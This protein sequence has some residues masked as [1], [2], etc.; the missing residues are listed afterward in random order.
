MEALA[1]EW[2]LDIC[3]SKLRFRVTFVTFSLQWR[4]VMR[5]GGWV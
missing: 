2:K 4:L 1:R 5:A 3:S